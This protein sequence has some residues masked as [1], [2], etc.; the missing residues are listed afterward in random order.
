MKELRFIATWWLLAA[1]FFGLSAQVTE[2]EL[3]ARLREATDERV[4]LEVL[5]ELGQTIVANKTE[6]AQRLFEEALTAAQRQKDH[7]SIAKSYSGLGAVHSLQQQQAEALQYLHT[8]LRY[9]RRT[10]DAE[11]EARILTQISRSQRFI[12][13]LDS[14]IFYS[15]V[16]LQLQE[17]ANI[18]TQVSNNYFE[19]G[20][21]YDMKG[22]LDAALEHFLQA[23][24][25]AEQSDNQ[26]QIALVLNSLGIV[27]RSAGNYEQALSYYLRA[28]DLYA[29]L[30]NRRNLGNVLHNIGDLYLQQ[31]DFANGLNFTLQGKAIREEIGDNYGLGYT[32]Q[33]LAYIYFTEK[34]DFATAFRYDSLAY[35]V[36]QKIG[37]RGGMSHSRTDMAWAALKLGRTRAANA[38][39]TEA[40]QIAQEL[41][42]RTARRNAYRALAQIAV[43][44]RRFETAFDWQRQYYEL[45][46][47][48][49]NEDKNK[50]VHELQ[51]QYET[52]KKE[53]Q[54]SENQ[55]LIEKRTLQRNGFI[56]VAV[57]SGLLAISIFLSLRSRLRYHQRLQAQRIRELEQAQKIVALDAMVQGQEEER[58][59]VAKDLHDGLGGLLSS[60]KHHF[61]A[62]SEQNE[63]LGALPVYQKTNAMLDEAHE[64]VRRIAHDM[65]PDALA[66]LGLIAAIEDLADSYQ[67]SMQVSVQ[68]FDC[69]KYFDKVL[70]VNLFRIVQE[71]LQNIAK[72]AR[73]TQVFIQ[74][75]QFDHTLTLTV[76]DNGVGFDYAQASESGLGLKNIASRVAWLGGSMNIETAP[77]KR[78]LTIIQTPL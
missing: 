69:E 45:K 25:A 40:L 8:G 46:D 75:S 24:E 56:I 53:Q 70:E 26:A 18:R 2:A 21:A 66:K 11:I 1:T 44:E 57:L 59:R 47:S 74:L 36:R 65:M 29:T 19:M 54:I 42:A 33:N 38:Y 30:D 35:E 60:I 55:I 31:Q 10:K 63:A 22:E 77:G 39:A 27:N 64:E 48:L 7:L 67:L 3:R 32:Y 13:Q 12:S 28:K 72:H 71:L 58:R 15:E 6:E 78:V 5:L 41:G 23:L 76:E 52:A 61:R 20:V 73:A 50:V 37:D 14:A 68:H 43:Q 62:V 49:F 34:E 16:A 4:H 9:A 51:V 17:K